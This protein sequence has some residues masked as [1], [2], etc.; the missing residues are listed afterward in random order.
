MR[1][2]PGTVVSLTLSEQFLKF[3]WGCAGWTPSDPLSTPHPTT[4][5]VTS[6]LG[7]F[8]H[9][10]LVLPM[11]R[12][13]EFSA[14]RLVANVSTEIYAY[15]PFFCKDELLS[16]FFSVFIEIFSKQS[17]SPSVPI[18]PPIPTGSL[19]FGCVPIESELFE[20]SFTCLAAQCI[21]PSSSAKVALH[22]SI[23]HIFVVRIRCVWC[24]HKVFILSVNLW[25]EYM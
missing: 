13:F 18:C 22:D 7:T 1:R 12:F 10:R 19:K 3:W 21:K 25:M 14:G 8:L 9:G 2:E 24:T 15:F 17:V 20:Q 11:I 6:S 4:S 16:C 23:L 5:S